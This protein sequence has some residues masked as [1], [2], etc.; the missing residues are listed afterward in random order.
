LDDLLMGG[1]RLPLRYLRARHGGLPTLTAGG[2]GAGPLEGLH[3]LGLI[4]HDRTTGDVFIP[5]DIIPL[6]PPLAQSAPPTVA[7]AQGADEPAF[8]AARDL[9]CLL[10]LLQAGDVQPL[11]GRW[12]PPNFLAAWGERCAMPPATPNARSEMQTGRRFL[13][14]LAEAAGLVGLY[15]PYLTPTPAAWAWL[16]AAPADRLNALWQTF[17]ASD[18][19]LWRIYR[20]P[21]H[22]L[23]PHPDKLIAAVI[24]ALPGHDPADPVAFAAALLA[25]QPALRD[26]LPANQLDADADLIA[27]I[28][29]LLKGPLVWMGALRQIEMIDR[30]RDRDRETLYLS[31]LSLSITAWGAHWLGMSPAPE[32]PLPPRFALASDIPNQKLTFTLAG[33]LPDPAHVICFETCAEVEARRASPLLH[34]YI[35]PASFVCCQHAKSAPKTPK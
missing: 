4:F 31:S 1:G 26:L 32:I 28:V 18:S 6:L 9:A 25:R 16:N 12:L 2:G 3:A 20:L 22:D 7:P 10:A 8:I 15:G 29:E 21:G 11:H 19:A 13:H 5:T 35:T 14:Y 34:G 24:Q 23:T 27:A 17:L 33:G 30:D